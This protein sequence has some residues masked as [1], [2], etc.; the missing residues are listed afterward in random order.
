ME[1]DFWHKRWEAGQIGFHQS[2]PNSFLVS[3]FKTLN[4]P[5][6]AR[7]FLPLCGKTHD[8]GWLLSQG[9]HVIGVELS[10]LAVD[11]LFDDLGVTTEAT[12]LGH[13]KL[14]SSESIDIYVCDIIDL[15][16][17][18]IGTVDAIYDRAALV[19]LPLRMRA[20]YAAHLAELTNAAPQL[21]VTFEY[22]QSL[23]SGP[24]F[25]I[26]EDEIR[27]LYDACYTASCLTRGTVQGGMK[28]HPATEAI[29]HLTPK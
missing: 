4:L 7:I 14:L 12:D 28:G 23:I 16:Q 27:C 11:Q 19:A 13:L 5:R 9:Y 15:T 6:G 25:A 10:A 21:L 8:I 3:H 17:D 18:T 20:D 24:P 1:A 29:W 26:W 22:D 2:K